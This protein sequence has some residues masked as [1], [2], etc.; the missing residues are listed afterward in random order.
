MDTTTENYFKENLTSFAMDYY[1][2]DGFCILD[3]NIFYFGMSTIQSLLYDFKSTNSKI[4]NK[5]MDIDYFKN[6]NFSEEELPSF[7]PY[8]TNDVLLKI[9]EFLAKDQLNFKTTEIYY[10][11][12]EDENDYVNIH[13]QNDY[14]VPYISTKYNK[15][16]DTI[17][18]TFLMGIDVIY[19]NYYDNRIYENKWFKLDFSFYTVNFK[20]YEMGYFKCNS[21]T[22]YNDIEDFI[23]EIENLPC[24]GNKE[25][26][27]KLTKRYYNQCLVKSIATMVGD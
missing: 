6:Y 11:Y 13:A 16:N 24:K 17:D 14:F 8:E 3:E 18:V 21:T 15:D 27:I 22:L 5:S 1:Q 25:N 23:K 7:A 20:D 19:K 4:I 2:R 12:G 10:N 26:I 9:L